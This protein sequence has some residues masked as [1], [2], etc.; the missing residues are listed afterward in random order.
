[1]MCWLLRT[2]GKPTSTV[3]STSSTVSS[4]VSAGSSVAS[5][6]SSSNEPRK[7][8]MGSWLISESTG[9]KVLLIDPHSDVTV[10][11]PAGGWGALGSPI[12]GCSAMLPVVDLQVVSIS[13]PIGRLNACQSGFLSHRASDLYAVRSSL[14]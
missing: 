3:S 9:S 7:R 12:G 13:E 5:S 11:D 6:G 8:V 2:L 1:M 10:G 14:P 4:T